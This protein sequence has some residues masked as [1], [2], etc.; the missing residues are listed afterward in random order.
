V[1]DPLRVRGRQDVEEPMSHEQRLLK[2]EPSARALPQLFYGLPLE[3]LHHEERHAVLRDVVVEHGDR[4][5]VT[6]RVRS[7]TLA[8]KSRADVRAKR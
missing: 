4:A 6:D 3:Q 2:G 5:R 1:D 7:V 8:Q